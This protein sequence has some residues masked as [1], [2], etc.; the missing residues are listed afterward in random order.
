M[1]CQYHK[2]QMGELESSKRR[3]LL[4]VVHVGHRERDEYVEEIAAITFNE[5][6]ICAGCET[7]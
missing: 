4:D 7:Q 6:L 5:I 2:Q 1:A 3:G